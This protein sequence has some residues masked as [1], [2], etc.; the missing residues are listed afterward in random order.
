MTHR[1]LLLLATLSA[2]TRVPSATISAPSAAA[3][4]EPEPTP[5]DPQPTP[6]VEAPAFECGGDGVDLERAWEL[7]ACH[8]EPELAVPFV[9]AKSM[10][11]EL[12]DEVRV[13]AGQR[14]AI[15]VLL[16]NVSDEESTLDVPT[17]YTSIAHA[18]ALTRDGKL[19]PPVNGV[20]GVAYGIGP[21]TVLRVRLAPG[22]AAKGLAIFCAVESQ[23]PEDCEHPR[24]TL[25]PGAYELRVY[26]RDSEGAELDGTVDLV[27]EAPK[28]GEGDQP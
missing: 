16:R 8:V 25:D 12:P 1:R 20:Y 9:A 27:I 22:E 17:T 28:G 19:V 21:Q 2:C 13:E 23:N 11:L 6:R 7:E 5:V 15:P 3:P 26:V 4:S 14:V 18:D 10:A 24:P